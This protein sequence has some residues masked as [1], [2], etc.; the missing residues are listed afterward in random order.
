MGHPW[1]IVSAVCVQR[2]PSLTRE[3]TA[4][5]LRYEEMKDTLRAERSRMS[6][7]ELEELEHFKMKKERQ[8]RALEEDMDT[9]PVCACRA[10]SML[11]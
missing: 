5:E 7:F 11:N 4:M 2:M 6:D 10:M 9:A 3:K 8:K 1:R